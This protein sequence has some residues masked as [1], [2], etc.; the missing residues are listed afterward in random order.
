MSEEEKP[1]PYEYINEQNFEI[2]QNCFK[3]GMGFNKTPD[4]IIEM[5]VQATDIPPGVVKA[6]VQLE[7]LP[8][9]QKLRTMSINKNMPNGSKFKHDV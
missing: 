3:F 6:L 4:K 2:I 7:L 5:I 1:H 9:M 8:T